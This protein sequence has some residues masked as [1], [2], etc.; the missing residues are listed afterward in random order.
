MVADKSKPDPL[1]MKCVAFDVDNEAFWK[2]KKI[3]ASIKRKGKKK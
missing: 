2:Y 3:E 1:V